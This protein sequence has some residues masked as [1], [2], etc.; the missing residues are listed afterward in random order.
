MKKETLNSAKEALKSNSLYQLFVEA[1]GT[2]EEIENDDSS[3]YALM[4]N[5]ETNELF[6]LKYATT[7]N[8]WAKTAESQNPWILLGYVSATDI[9]M[10]DPA[11]E[12]SDRLDY[13]FEQHEQMERE[14]ETY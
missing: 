7:E 14:R 3:R 6:F 10:G 5:V 1:I 2:P 12:I 11:S 9:L 13:E 8:T 4:F